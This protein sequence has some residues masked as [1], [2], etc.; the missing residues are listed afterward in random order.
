MG[1]ND[2]A[3]RELTRIRFQA[4]EWS[5]NNIKIT[6][7]GKLGSGKTTIAIAISEALEKLGYKIAQLDT[8]YNPKFDI[9]RARKTQIVIEERQLPRV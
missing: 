1:Y 7:E 5:V 3:I 6:V 4:N 2:E 9:E 8:S